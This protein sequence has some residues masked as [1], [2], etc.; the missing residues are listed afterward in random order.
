MDH[1]EKPS[2]I[3]NYTKTYHYTFFNGICI[4]FHFPEEEEVRTEIEF[5]SY[6]NCPLIVFLL[7]N[8]SEM[9]PFLFFA[10]YPN[11][12]YVDIVGPTVVDISFKS[13]VLLN[14]ED[15]PCIEGVDTS[16]TSSCLVNLV[17]KEIVKHNYTCVPPPLES[18]LPAFKDKFCQDKTKYKNLI[19]M[20]YSYVHQDQICQPSC[21]MNSYDTIGLPIAVSDGNNSTL[22]IVR[23]GN[24]IEI[25]TTEHYVHTELSIL[26]ST[27]G[28]LGMFLGW[29]V[30]QNY[31]DWLKFIRKGF[32]KIGIWK[33]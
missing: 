11:A 24:S 3:V 31:L 30:Y 22:I 32:Y 18:I 16:A 5:L 28:A 8:P 1:P 4:S 2:K 15:R 17:E 21:I 29:S 6:S 20:A 12:K 25:V 33:K 13:Y 19:L 10:N 26:T 23:L 7:N 14:M 27:G 9:L